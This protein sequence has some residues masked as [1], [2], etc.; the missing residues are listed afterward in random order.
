[1]LSSQSA[2]S[3][4]EAMIWCSVEEMVCCQ[5]RL[6]DGGGSGKSGEAMA[7]VGCAVI[8]V[9]APSVPARDSARDRRLCSLCLSRAYANSDN[10]AI[11]EH[12]TAHLSSV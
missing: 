11:E 7:Q 9:F 3:C 4:D 5:Q 6:L 10:T 2:N 1:M 8:V 12:H